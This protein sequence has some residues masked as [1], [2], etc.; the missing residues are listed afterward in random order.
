MFQTL[1]HVFLFADMGSNEELPDHVQSMGG[2]NNIISKLM[3]NKNTGTG[4][5]IEPTQTL[6]EETA[7]RV[8]YIQRVYSQRISE[9][10][11]KE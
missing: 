8:I 10:E 9:K 7:L 2:L 5:V 3:F 1:Y 6:P 11:L 4:V